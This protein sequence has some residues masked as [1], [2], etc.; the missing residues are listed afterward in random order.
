MLSGM[1]CP[2]RH[3][4]R[5]SLKIAPKE[6]GCAARAILQSSP[7]RFGHVMGDQQ[8]QAIA[9]AAGLN[10]MVP[11]VRSVV[12]PAFVELVFGVKD[13]TTVATWYTTVATVLQ[14][15]T[16]A[17]RANPLCRDSML[18]AVGELVAA[19]KE[20]DERKRRHREVV[21]DLRKRRCS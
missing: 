18:W 3:P 14:T 10:P 13:Q 8:V 15:H 2:R 9:R 20:R 21:A 17:L 7:A 16:G 4:P 19:L 1:R 6:A 11:V 5:L 12:D